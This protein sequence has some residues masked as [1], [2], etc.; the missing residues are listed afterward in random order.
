R[1]RSTVYWRI[2]AFV[3]ILWISIVQQ[4]QMAR[5]QHCLRGLS[6]TLQV[7]AKTRGGLPINIRCIYS[8]RDTVVRLLAWKWLRRACLC[9]CLTLMFR[10]QER[11]PGSCYRIRRMPSS[12][13]LCMWTANHTTWPR[14]QRPFHRRAFP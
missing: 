6:S 2:W 14:F 4:A 9:W 13:R 11:P 1:L 10:L 8:T 5:I 7:V 3:L 12:T